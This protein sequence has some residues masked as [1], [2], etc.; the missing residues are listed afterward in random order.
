MSNVLFIPNWLTFFTKTVGCK[1][2][3]FISIEESNF[4]NIISEQIE[5]KY[6][7]F[8]KHYLTFSDP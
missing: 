3:F 2:W 8:K 6:F 5:C 1:N 4:L 7:Y